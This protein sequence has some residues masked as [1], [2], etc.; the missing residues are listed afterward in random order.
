MVARPSAPRY[1][2]AERINLRR[3]A[4]ETQPEPLIQRDDLMLKL[5]LS[6]LWMPSLLLGVCG[7]PVASPAHEEEIL[8]LDVAPNSVPC[9]AEG[10]QR[11]LRVREVG[12]E[13]W[14]YFYDPI[15]GFDFEEGFRY[16]LEIAKRTI[17]NPLADATNAEYRLIRIL[18]REAAEG[19]P[20]Q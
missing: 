6:I 14:T 16:R 9:T 11:C 7:A 2:M 17:P 13:R 10:P 4:A 15:R 3:S 8:I 5:F 12:L 1:S 19:I 18:S 20:Q